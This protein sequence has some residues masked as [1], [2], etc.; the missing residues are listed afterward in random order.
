VI[1]LLVTKPRKVAPIGD[2]V[3]NQ[4]SGHVLREP[5]PG[6]SADGQ[7]WG[8]G[9]VIDQVFDARAERADGFEVGKTFDKPWGVFPEHS[10]V[11]VTRFADLGPDADID[12]GQVAGQIPSQ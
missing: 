10:K 8:D 6:Q 5:G 9:W 4:P 12:A 2:D 11:N 1:A 7:G 3:T